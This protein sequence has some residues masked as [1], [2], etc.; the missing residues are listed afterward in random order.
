MVVTAMVGVWERVAVGS[1][2]A[3][4]WGVGSGVLVE[5]EVTAG[6]GMDSW[7]FRDSVGRLVRVG[8]GESLIS[9]QANRMPLVRERT[10]R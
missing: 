5:V 6:E 3:V 10:R 9:R 2:V 7:I 4:G 1:G 8:R